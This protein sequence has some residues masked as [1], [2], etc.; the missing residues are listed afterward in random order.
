MRPV[1]TA[2]SPPETNAATPQPGNPAASGSAE[3]NPPP[4][5]KKIPA[6]PNPAQ[7]A[8]R[9][10]L[11]LL[12]ILLLI[13]GIIGFGYLRYTDQFIRTEDAFVSGHQVQI[14]AEIAG[15]IKTVPWQNNQTVSQGAVLFTLDA[16]PYQAAV[17][18]AEANLAAAQRSQATAAAAVVTAQ[19]AVAQAQASAHQAED[20]L[21]RIQRI[22]VQQFVSAQDLTDARAAVAVAQAGVAQANAALDQA[23][24]NAGQPGQQNDRIRA[25][26]AQLT[27]AEYQLRRTSITAPMTGRLANYT[28]QPGQPVAPAQPLF[29]MVATDGLWI[30][31]NFKETEIGRIHIGM[32]VEIHSDVFPQQKITGTVVSIS[33]GAGTAFSLL[34]PQNATGNWVKVTQRVPVRIALDAKPG[35]PPLPI[36]T[37]ATVQILRVEH[38]MGWLAATL[39]LFGI[40]N[41]SHADSRY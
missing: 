8:S 21:A 39:S 16:T 35:E 32:P 2:G 38:P 33:A 41:H 17:A 12:L 14:G 3:S 1:A 13:G 10:R 37:S 18:A 27:S 23:R 22:K 36:G 24:A 34:P 25:A 30:D 11:V 9:L 19:A 31:A 26:Q 6:L 4:P 20:H 28:I 7:R 15:Q 29:S 40:H 5:P